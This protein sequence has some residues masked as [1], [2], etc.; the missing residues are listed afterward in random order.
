M[1]GAEASD[2]GWR[3][4]VKPES[5]PSDATGPDGIL[6]FRFSPPSRSAVGDMVYSR[7]GRFRSRISSPPVTRVKRVM[8]PKWGRNSP[9][10]PIT[11]FICCMQK[12][13]NS[14]EWFSILSST[15]TVW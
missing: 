8:K 7:M 14:T 9:K 1:F 15:T 6:I 13:E 2:A 12:F 3:V 11:F 10:F 5:S 4:R